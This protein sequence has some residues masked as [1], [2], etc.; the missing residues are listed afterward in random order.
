MSVETRSATPE[1][2]PFLAWVMQEAA[3]S[4]LPRGIWDFVLPGDEAARLDVLAELCTSEAEHFAHHSRFRV[5]TVDGEPA[6]ALSAYENARHGAKHLDGPMAVALTRRGWS[7][8]D[9]IAMGRRVAT[10]ELLGYPNPDGIWIVEWVATKPA[11]RG[12]S[13]VRRLLEEVLEEGRAQ[14]FERAQIG[15]LLGNLRA[16]SAYEG[17]GFSVV[18]EYRHAAFEDQYGSPGLA[19]MQRAL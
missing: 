18:E 14:G 3:R 6:S 1:D 13:L 4:H 9:L 8:D 10:F 15:F 7:P 11:H 5:L 2:A 16:K 12:R 17:V 19:R